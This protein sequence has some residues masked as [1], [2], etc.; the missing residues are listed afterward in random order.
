MSRFARS[1]EWA[2]AGG[3]CL[4]GLL[5]CGGGGSSS[6]ASQPT[7][8]ADQAVFE[9]F[10]LSPNI[11]YVLSPF[12]LP[13][14]GSPVSGVHFF[15][16]NGYTLALSPLTYG[17]Q[18]ASLTT[19]ISITNTPFPI[20]AYAVVPNRYLNNGSIVVSSSPAWKVNYSYQG[21]GVRLDFL[22]ATGTT[23]LFSFLR[24]N[25]S[26]V[27]LTG[28]VISAPSALKTYYGNLFSNPALLNPSA[29]WLP[30]AE[31]EQFSQIYVNDTYLVRDNGTQAAT[32]TNPIPVASGT[33]I[34]ALM[35][36]SG[37]TFNGVLYTPS[38]GSF[39]VISG[40]NT[41]VANA[42][43]SGQVFYMVFFEL[44]GNV[45]EGFLYKANTSVND[46]TKMNQAA[47]LSIQV[48]L[49]F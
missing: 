43:V 36:S 40:V 33:T 47:A 23:T 42:P 29:T 25:F 6:T 41:Y 26:T 18:N 31:W 15:A 8:S 30:G 21:T 32:G 13:A 14:S 10:A 34:A 5:A 22:D 45:Y 28:T 2:V 49:T 17:R 20:P 35:G 3:I 7:L 24:S 39:S 9:H 1:R 27:P 4:L 11:T 44:N 12:S 37:F 38:N 48:A 19:P 16:A 46:C